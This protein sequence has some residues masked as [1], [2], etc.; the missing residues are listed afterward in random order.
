VN[1]LHYIKWLFSVWLW[2]QILLMST[3]PIEMEWNAFIVFRLPI[4]KNFLCEKYLFLLISKQLC[5]AI[6]KRC[7][8]LSWGLGVYW[9]QIFYFI[10]T[11]ILNQAIQQTTYLPDLRSMVYE[12][13]TRTL[14]GHIPGL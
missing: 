13:F 9:K 6:S 4:W 1:L 7:F 14:P 12:V 11:V 3:I 2:E 5:C 10:Y 8:H